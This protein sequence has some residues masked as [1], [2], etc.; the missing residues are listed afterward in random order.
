MVNERTIISFNSSRIPQ[1]VFLP[2]L[3]RGQLVPTQVHG[4]ISGEPIECDRNWWQ[5]SIVRWGVAVSFCDVQ[6]ATH[7]YS[8]KNIQCENTTYEKC[9]CAVCSLQVWG[10]M[11]SKVLGRSMWLTIAQLT[12]RVPIC[13]S[14]AW[15]KSAQLT[16]SV[17]NR[18][19]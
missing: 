13:R 14:L 11:Q 18:K 17:T 12:N 1:F 10:N 7:F 2:T 19:A 9:D 3:H 15:R 6:S 5:S 16:Y 8:R 4:V